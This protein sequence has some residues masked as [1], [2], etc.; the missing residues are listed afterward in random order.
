MN[1]HLVSLIVKTLRE[2]TAGTERTLPDELDAD[3][4]LFGRHGL[5][6]SLSLVTLVIAVE[7]EIER[8][9]GVT[10]SLADE[11]AMSQTSSPYRTIGALAAYAG[12]L[13]EGD[14]QRV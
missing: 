8:A 3:T 2:V 1:E 10:V 6:D 9:F 5:L 13:V 4:A 12:R 14:P 7:Q 11:R